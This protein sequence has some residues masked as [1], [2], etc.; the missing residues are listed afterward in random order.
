MREIKDVAS[1]SHDDAIIRREV[2]RGVIAAGLYC[3][4]CGA[5]VKRVAHKEYQTV[6]PLMDLDYLTELRSRLG[7]DKDRPTN[8]RLAPDAEGYPTAMQAL[9]EK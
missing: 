6:G 4:D 1:C 8:I 9:K 3:L 5:L 7:L 2:D